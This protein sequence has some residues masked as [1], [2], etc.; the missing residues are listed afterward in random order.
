MIARLFSPKPKQIKKALT[1]VHTRVHTVRTVRADHVM[2]ISLLLTTHV[3]Q[4]AEF[5]DKIA[6]EVQAFP[7][8]RDWFALPFIKN[9]ELQPM[10]DT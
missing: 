5:F 1:D 3:T 4:V 7:E 8:W 6:A 9:P 2:T 10:Y